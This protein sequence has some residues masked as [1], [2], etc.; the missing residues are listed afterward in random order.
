M[1]DLHPDNTNPQVKEEEEDEDVVKLVNILKSEHQAVQLQGLTVIRTLLS[2]DEHPPIQKVIKAGVLPKLLEFMLHDD[3]KFQFESAWA[4]T[5]ICAGKSNFVNCV[6]DHGGLDIILSLL[7]HPV[8]EVVDQCLWAL[9][10][11]TGDDLD[12]RNLVLEKDCIPL[13]L[14]CVN[15]FKP[16]AAI[17]KSATWA[18]SNLA[19]GR[20]YPPWEK[21]KVVLPLLNETIHQTQCQ[22]TLS[23]ALWCFSYLSDL[24]IQG[25]I[26]GC[27]V[28][29]I[30]NHLLSNNLT[31]LAPAMRTLGNLVSGE[32]DQTEVVVKCPG[33]LTRIF[34]LTSHPRKIMRKESLWII[35]NIAA[36]SKEHLDLILENPNHLKAI[37][38]SLREDEKDVAGE[39]AVVLNNLVC[40]ASIQQINKLIV[41]HNY[42]DCLDNLLGSSRIESKIQTQCFESVIKLLEAGVAMTMVLQ[43]GMNFTTKNRH[44]DFVKN[45]HDNSTCEKVRKLALHLG[46]LLKMFERAPCDHCGGKKASDQDEDS[47][48]EWTDYSGTEAGSQESD[49]DEDEDD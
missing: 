10:N 49:N 5:N 40:G 39:A 32:D 34:E 22:A 41:E 30:V 21:I 4:L 48:A 16:S 31:I 45:I 20:P 7:N 8:E 47:E 24:S 12:H 28:Q 38:R 13:I 14:E 26:D 46:M 42:L 44:V 2:H 3:T 33:F 6:I 17:L 29:S 19:R 25:V 18:I 27:S 23:S 36:G 1:T 15:K 9:A 43:T 35:S 11:I 37:K